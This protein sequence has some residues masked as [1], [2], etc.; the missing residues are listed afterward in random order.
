MYILLFS[1][2]LYFIFFM[3]LY[4]W[5]TIFKKKCECLDIWH[6]YY[7]II[8]IILSLLYF[9]FNILYFVIYQKIFTKFY[10]YY[11]VYTL[12]SAIITILFIIYINKNCKCYEHI[13]KELL[14]IFVAITFILNSILSISYIY[15]IIKTQYVT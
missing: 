11:M 9:L 13:S 8:F 7:I 15:R 1:I 2:L 12:I 14:I 5:L 4:Y 10:D 6:Y 3:Y